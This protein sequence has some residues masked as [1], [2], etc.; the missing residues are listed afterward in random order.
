MNI[1]KLHLRIFGSIFS[2]FFWG[3]ESHAWSKHHLSYSAQYSWHSTTPTRTPTRQTRLQS[4][5]RHMLFPRD[6]ASRSKKTGTTYGRNVDFATWRRRHDGHTRMRTQ[7]QRY[8]DTHSHH[9]SHIC[10][11]THTWTQTYAF[12]IG[13]RTLYDVAKR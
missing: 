10:T 13:I 2:F 12:R 8:I 1:S 3:G 4:Y 6:S 9:R 5:V 11:H 7:R